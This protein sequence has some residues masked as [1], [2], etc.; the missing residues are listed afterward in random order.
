MA[1][2][3]RSFTTGAT[4]DIDTGKFDY[5]G[6]LSPRVLEAHGRYMHICRKTP[7]GLRDS[8]NW[9]R[10]IPVP[11]YL[12]SMW[13]HFMDVWKH[14]RGLPTKESQI[15]NLLALHFNVDGMLHETLKATSPEVIEAA[16]QLFE[17]HR[18]QE[19]A[20]RAARK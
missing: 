1:E 20:E 4:R 5:E 3:E 13:R 15:V 10:G 14:A 2:A 7:T 6:F 8:D 12:K 17:A 11:V 16:F 18:D 9:Q 19:N